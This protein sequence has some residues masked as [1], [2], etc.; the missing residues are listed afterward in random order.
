MVGDKCAYVFVN[1][2][3]DGCQANRYWNGRYYILQDEWGNAATS[4]GT[5]GYCTTYGPKYP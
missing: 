4:L 2:N 5:G 3:Y 1:L